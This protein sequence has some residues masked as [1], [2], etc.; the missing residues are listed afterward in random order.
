MDAAKKKDQPAPGEYPAPSAPPEIRPMPEPSTPEHPD[1]E[2]LPQ[3]D[4]PGTP[5]PAEIPTPTGAYLFK[6]QMQPASEH[7]GF[8]DA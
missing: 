2:P 1:G 3:P 5:S 4:T 8:F 7:K 6:L